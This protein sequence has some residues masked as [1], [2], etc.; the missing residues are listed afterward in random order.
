MAKILKDI[1]VNDVKFWD[2]VNWGLNFV[3]VLKF[4]IIV[5]IMLGVYVAIV[6]GLF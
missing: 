6:K 3:F 2:R 4:K 5:V 1:F